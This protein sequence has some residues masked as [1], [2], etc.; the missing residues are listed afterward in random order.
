MP[1]GV[2]F[3]VIALTTDEPLSQQ[4]YLSPPEHR[5]KSEEITLIRG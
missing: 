3:T 2:K 4:T 1:K 5:T